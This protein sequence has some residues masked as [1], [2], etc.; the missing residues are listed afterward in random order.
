MK[1]KMLPGKYAHQ[2]PRLTKKFF[3]VVRIAE[4]KCEVVSDPLNWSLASEKYN[5]T[6]RNSPTDNFVGIVNHKM[7]FK[8]SRFGRLTP[9]RISN[10]VLF[11]PAV[12]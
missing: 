8:A 10:H 3:V 5:E 7:K 1:M 6:K 9:H 2:I 11:T 4:G 12:I